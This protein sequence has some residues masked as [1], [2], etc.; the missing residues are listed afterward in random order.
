MSSL[1]DAHHQYLTLHPSR[2]EKFWL[3]MILNDISAQLLAK[4]ALVLLLS[5]KMAFGNR[6]Q[7]CVLQERTLPTCQGDY[8]C[9]DGICHAISCVP[10]ND[11]MCSNV[12]H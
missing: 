8:V 12:V 4:D 3:H 6:L 11:I 5:C 1:L 9:D 2:Q 10:K 7:M